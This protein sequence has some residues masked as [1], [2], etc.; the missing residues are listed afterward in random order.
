M[1]QLKRLEQQQDKPTNDT[2][3]HLMQEAVHIGDHS[4]VSMMPAQRCHRWTDVACIDCVW[5]KLNDKL[6]LQHRASNVLYVACM[7]LD[8]VPHMCRS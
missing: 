5:C 6:T 1:M 4:I 3:D 2:Y 8:N 7:Q